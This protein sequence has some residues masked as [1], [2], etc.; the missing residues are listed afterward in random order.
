MG[1]VEKVLLSAEFTQEK[2]TRPESLEEFRKLKFL[3]YVWETLGN[4]KAFPDLIQEK[5]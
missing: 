2:G 4:F 5:K 1:L 3:I